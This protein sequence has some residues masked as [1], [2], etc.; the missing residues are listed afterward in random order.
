MAKCVLHCFAV[1]PYTAI[2]HGPGEAHCRC[3]THGW[4]FGSTPV[5][6]LTQCPLGRIDD[7]VE[8]VMAK[9]DALLAEQVKP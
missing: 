1:Y 3:E 8:E 5:T 7:K 4:D 9:L 6:A 2:M